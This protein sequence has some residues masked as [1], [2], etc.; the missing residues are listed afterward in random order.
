MKLFRYSRTILF[1]GIVV[2]AIGVAT[3]LNDGSTTRLNDTKKAT[4]Y[5]VPVTSYFSALEDFTPGESKKAFVT[6]EG[7]NHLAANLGDTQIEIWADGETLD[8]FEVGIVRWDKVTPNLK[9]LTYKGKSLWDDDPIDY[10]LKA[11]IEVSEFEYQLLSFDP[12]KLI[13]INFLG[14]IMLSRHVNTQMKRYGYDYPWRIVKEITADA[15]ITFANLEVPISDLFKVPSEGMSFVASTKNLKYLKEA[16]ID[17]VSLANNHTANFGTQAFT[18]TLK[19]LDE[20][21]IGICG[22]GLTEAEARAAK[23]MT[24]RGVTFNFL[25]QSAIVGSLY[26]DGKNPGVPYLGLEPWYRRNQNSLDDLVAD[27]ER[28]AGNSVLIDSPHWGVEYKQYPNDDQREAA[29]LMVDRGADLVIGT[30]PHVVQSAEYYADKYI[31]YSLGNFIFDQEWSTE[32][33]QGVML[34]SYFYGDKNV[35]NVLVPLQIENYAQPSFVAAP[36]AG[37]IIGDIKKHSVGF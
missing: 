28:S 19:N 14:D 12:E 13:K 6:A 4:V 18:D 35:S 21:G 34:S 33:K 31:I 30:H 22:A 23:S 26:A 27:I 25:C 1:I 9:T 7:A 37:K 15:D 5:Y 20:V 32:T 11:E 16:G 24:A 36:I 8:E 10:E 17:V 3:K 2:M 29:R